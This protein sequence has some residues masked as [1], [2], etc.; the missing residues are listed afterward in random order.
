MKK[1]LLANNIQ[2]DIYDPDPDNL[3][4]IGQKAWEYDASIS[5]HHNSY[6]GTGNPYHCIMIDPA[7]PSSWKQYTSR[8][9]IAMAKALDGTVADTKIMAGGTNGLDGVYEAELSVLNA[10]A[11]DP[12]KKPPYHCLVEAYFLN[13]MTNVSAC[14]EASRKAAEAIALFLSE[15]PWP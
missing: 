13:P 8:M 4:G 11:K 1:V 12:D 14:M 5:F 2:A 7:A 6:S 10:S 9:C 3:T 15:N